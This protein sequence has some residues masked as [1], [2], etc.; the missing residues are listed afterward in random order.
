MEEHRDKGEGERTGMLLKKWCQMVLDKT[1]DKTQ[2][3]ALITL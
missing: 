3:K 1:E 2:K